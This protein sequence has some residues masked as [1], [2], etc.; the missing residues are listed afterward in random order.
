VYGTS[1]G[2]RRERTLGVLLLQTGVEGT[3]SLYSCTH[4]IDQF[5]STDP[6][7]EGGTVGPSMGRLWTEQP[8][9]AASRPLYR[10]RMSNGERFVS[11]DENCESPDQTLE[12]RLGYVLTAAPV[13]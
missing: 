3:A 4:G 10:C 2:Y 9:D 11:V 5:P 6:A 7:C 1:A 13:Q 8:A 12:K